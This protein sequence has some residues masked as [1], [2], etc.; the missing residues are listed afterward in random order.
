MK[1][2][3]VESLFVFLIVA[4]A[5]LLPLLPPAQLSHAVLSDSKIERTD[6]LFSACLEADAEFCLIKSNKSRPDN[7]TYPHNGVSL[8]PAQAGSRQSICA[9]DNRKISISVNNRGSLWL[10]FCSLLI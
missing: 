2:H 6:R 10:L 7:N 1:K 4:I 9:A 3:I 5:Q 8:G